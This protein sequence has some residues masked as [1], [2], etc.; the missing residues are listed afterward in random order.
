M[1]Q[2]RGPRTVGSDEGGRPLTEKDVTV[3]KFFLW[4]M[5]GLT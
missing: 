5:R 3:T 2:L 1:L 4:R